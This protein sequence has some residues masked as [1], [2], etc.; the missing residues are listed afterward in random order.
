EPSHGASPE[1]VSFILSESPGSLVIF[2]AESRDFS[3]MREV[4]RAGVMDIIMIPDEEVMLGDVVRRALRLKQEMVSASA[5]A[6]FFPG[7]TT[8]G[9]GQVVAFYSGKGGVGKSLIS[10]TLAHTLQLDY[11]YNVL[12]VDLNLQNG[13]ISPLFGLKENR[14]IY[15]LIPVMGELNETHLRNVVA[16]EN[17]SQ[18]DV[19][20]SPSDAEKGEYVTA[21][22]IQ[23]LLRVARR[24]YD[25]VV[26]D[27]PTGMDEKNQMAL[28]EADR[29]YYIS[30]LDIPSLMVL[31]QSLDLFRRLNMDTSPE[32]LIVVF[33]QIHDRNEIIV[34]D[35]KKME[36]INYFMTLPS[37]WKNIQNKLNLTEP[38]R[39][40]PQEKKISPF[41]KSIR[42]LAHALISGTGVQEE[43]K[44]EGTFLKKLNPFAQ[45][46]HTKKV[47]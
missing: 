13:G 30:T 8:K 46:N 20:V 16:R 12:L 33:N 6:R 37:D 40:Q 17:V 27:L 22:H 4:Q 7:T 35:L 24:Y 1:T 19:L 32:H 43:E 39:K 23:R 26:V 9:K 10:G 21:D 11:P 14:S 41:A 28:M 45:K 44:N 15:D 18:M 2:L 5:A 38:I 31:R 34:N 36:E 47:L 29:I 25:Y 3:M 42:Q